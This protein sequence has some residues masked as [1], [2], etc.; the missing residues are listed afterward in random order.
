[1]QSQLTAVYS[2][3]MR[4]IFDEQI[5]KLFSLIDGQVR[6]VNDLHPQQ[7]IVSVPLFR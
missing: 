7:R 2:N 5:E 4:E 6:I 1:M 3:V